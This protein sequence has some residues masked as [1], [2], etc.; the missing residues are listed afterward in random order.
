MFAVLERTNITSSALTQDSTW[1]YLKRRPGALT[2]TVHSGEQRATTL[3]SALCLRNKLRPPGT[4]VPET[5]DLIPSIPMWV[6]IG[7]SVPRKLYLGT[8]GGY[9]HEGAPAWKRGQGAAQQSL[10]PRI[11]RCEA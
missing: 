4:L 7:D 8:W 2:A 5:E 1:T 3:L 11:I 9:Y 10:K 6:A